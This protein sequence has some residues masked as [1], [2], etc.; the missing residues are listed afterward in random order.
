MRD[1]E[2]ATRRRESSFRQAVV[3]TAAAMLMA[4]ASSANAEDWASL[5]ITDVEAFPD[6]RI[7][8]F[9]SQSKS[10]FRG[11]GGASMIWARFR[12]FFSDAPPG[13]GLGPHYHHF[14]EWALVLDGDYVIHEPVSPRQ[15]HGPLY[16]YE[17]GT[18]LDRPAYSIHGGT[19]AIGGMRSQRPCTLII[20]EE[21]DGSVITLGP[22]GDHF[23]PD[24]LDDKPDPYD[25][26]W[27]SVP[28]FTNPWIVH[29]GSQLEWEPDD[30][31]P[32]RWVKWLSDD[33]T[34]GFRARLIKAPPGWS[35]EHSTSPQWYEKANRFI[36]V[37]WGD[38]KIQN[39][40]ADGEAAD[41]VDT[42]SDWFIHQAPR[43]L[44][45]HGT[46]PAT[47]NGA[48]WLEVTYAEGIT[49]G[50]GP[51]EEPRYLKPRILK[52]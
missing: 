21:G 34:R 28:S 40:D 47:E 38:L 51:I 11:P 44:L 16:Q 10:I 41:L 46:G 20:F 39:F 12:P 14:H 52:P 5:Q 23:K 8:R 6:D 45:S 19:W 24:F 27:K 43:A 22:D 35:S 49:V 33:P 36:Y 31:E 48:I 37:T 13:A 50:G 18:W 9:Y 42:D 4:V 30:E 7:P 26:D 29:S 3:S 1:L 2:F 25:P 17:E 32:G 15:K